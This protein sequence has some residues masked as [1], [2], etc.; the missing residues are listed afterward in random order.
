VRQANVQSVTV[1]NDE[2]REWSINPTISTE[3]DSA[4]GYFTGA[5]KIVV[6]PN[7][8]AQYEVSYQPTTMTKM[9][10]VKRKE[11]EEEVEEEVMDT[12]K[13]TLFFPLPNG[14]ALLYKLSGTATAPDSEGDINE[15]A[16][17]K[18]VKSVIIPMKN[19]SR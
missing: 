9:K 1:T 14:T 5:S 4:K 7:G 12:H 18:K 19:W 16:T 8:T 13:G 6:P 11:G 10:K 3:L 17:A 15:N 2:A